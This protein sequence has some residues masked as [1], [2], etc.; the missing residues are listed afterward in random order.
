MD[1]THLARGLNG[2]ATFDPSSKILHIDPY[3]IFPFSFDIHQLLATHHLPPSQTTP[4]PAPLSP[5]TS[6][7]ASPTTTFDEEMLFRQMELAIH[8]EE[9]EDRLAKEAAHQSII[10]ICHAMCM[11]DEKIQ[12]IAAALASKTTTQ[13]TEYLCKMQ[14][15]FSKWEAGHA[16]HHATA[17]Q[18]PLENTTVDIRQRIWALAHVVYDTYA[19]R[20][21]DKWARPVAA[22][23]DANPTFEEWGTCAEKLLKSRGC[24]ITLKRWRDEFHEEPALQTILAELVAKLGKYARSRARIT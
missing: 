5:H 3:G 7:T 17:L 1:V 24:K 4:T 9:E 22:K 6:P 8:E 20:W 21:P 2:T 23:D 19:D 10:E 16:V 11:S 13:M 12:T 18:Q 15:H 14:R